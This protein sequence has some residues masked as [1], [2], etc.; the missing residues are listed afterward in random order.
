MPH[1]LKT[2]FCISIYFQNILS[3]SDSQDLESVAA[4]VEINGEQPNTN[5]I[6]VLCQSWID[7]FVVSIFQLPDFRWRTEENFIRYYRFCMI[8]NLLGACV[9]ANNH[10]LA[11]QSDWSMIIPPC[12]E[13]IEL[14]PLAAFKFSDDILRSS[15]T[16]NIRRIGSLC[17]GIITDDAK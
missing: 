11:S 4:K 14:A 13:V 12:V 5:S 2:I 1:T 17:C 10:C 6:L 15:T 16:N 7:D 8:K 3:D 9:S